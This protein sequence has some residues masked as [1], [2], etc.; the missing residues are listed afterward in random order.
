MHKLLFLFI[1]LFLIGCAHSKIKV[2]DNSENITNTQNISSEKDV[3]QSFY[4]LEHI[5][6]KSKKNIESIKFQ[7]NSQKCEKEYCEIIP[8]KKK[9]YNQIIYFSQKNIEKSQN[10][11][12]EANKL[13]LKLFK[14]EDIIKNYKK[15][16][17][18][19][20][21]QKFTAALLNK[22]DDSINFS[23][24]ESYKFLYDQLN[25][26]E[27][28]QD[29]EQTYLRASLIFHNFNEVEYS[30]K[31]IKKALEIKSP[32]EYARI[33]YWAGIILKDN[34]FLE[35]VIN[36]RPYTYHAVISAELIGVPL[37]D[38]IK[39]REKIEAIR[40]DN[41]LTKTVEQLLFYNNSDEAYSLIN[42]NIT[43]LSASE[44]LYFAKL[45][46]QKARIDVSIK[47]VS[48][49]AN[50]WP[51]Y[52]NEQFIVIAYKKDFFDLFEKNAKDHNLDPYLLIS[53]SKQESG[54]FEKA[55][56]PAN[57]R[58]LMQLLPSTARTISVNKSKNLFNP[59]D[60]IFLGSTY[61][62][63]LLLDF[64][65]VELSLAG[66]N[67]GPSNVIKW[68]KNYGFNDPV[69]FADLIPF[70]ETRI[71]VA[72]ILRNHYFYNKI[73]NNIENKISLKLN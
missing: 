27:T 13:V 73:Y 42:F 57:A 72:S 39:N 30:H 1:S 25:N 15:Y 29:L 58:G 12:L 48:R 46:D 35:K 18:N 44:L 3:N 10:Q 62:N 2:P 52:M 45:F 67:A 23:N 69:L 59:E 5:L 50:V 60:N 61:F 37:W 38:K 26:C 9:K 16:T 70:R 65:K 36:N 71:Y 34:S 31:S 28:D 8:P 63:S 51:E 4:N 33:N 22:I 21:P 49:I 17:Y 64:N 14:D 47:L 55:K 56:S 43:K 66:Y 24:I 11:S 54:L 6:P 20:C 32:K 19:K 68:I 40:N 53:L 7:I 41:L